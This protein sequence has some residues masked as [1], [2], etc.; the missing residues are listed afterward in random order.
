MST[1][2]IGI[3]YQPL[4]GGPHMNKLGF[5]LL[6]ALTSKGALASEVGAPFPQLANSTA[7]IA[8]AIAETGASSSLAVEP[9]QEVTM[10]HQHVPLHSYT[11]NAL[12]EIAVD[13][14]RRVLQDLETRFASR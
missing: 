8:V 7:L 5:L 14:E 1:T 4:E 3:R 12:E 6:A 13:Y 9:E 11:E 2:Y 10:A